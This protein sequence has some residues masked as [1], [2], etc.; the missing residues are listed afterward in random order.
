MNDERDTRAT[1]ELVSRTYREHSTEQTPG[2]LNRKILDMA[3]DRPGRIEGL[4]DLFKTWTRPLALAATIALSFAI[5]LEVTRLP[6]PIAPPSMPASAAVDSVREEFRQKDSAIVD[7]AQDQARL[8]DGSNRNDSLIAEPQS[9]VTLETQQ[10]QAIAEV[11]AEV[12][13]TASATE[14]ESV[15]KTGDATGQARPNRAARVPSSDLNDA[16]AAKGAM[17]GQATSQVSIAKE[18][19]DSLSCDVGK[20]ETAESWLACI[21]ELKR[22][23]AIAAAETEYAEYILQFPVE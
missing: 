20:R 4:Q 23:G 10:N 17:V 5:V 3:A 15:L 11:P 19:G 14:V 18:S 6:E 8:R 9:A 13:E 2:R 7:R 21:E 16:D 12:P 22:S 1:E